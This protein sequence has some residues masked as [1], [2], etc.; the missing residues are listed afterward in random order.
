MI[1][2]SIPEAKQATYRKM[3]FGADKVA[4]ENAIWKKI[5]VKEN[6]EE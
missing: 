1:G 3:R 6:A 2:V 4:G 5:A